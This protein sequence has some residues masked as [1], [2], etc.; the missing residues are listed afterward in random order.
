M[1]HEEARREARALIDDY[2]KE[3]VPMGPRVRPLSYGFNEAN[4]HDE[5]QKTDISSDEES[6]SQYGP[7]AD[8]GVSSAS[9]ISD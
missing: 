3:N 7:F 5:S 2:N 8:R 4:E 1:D 6:V 9:E